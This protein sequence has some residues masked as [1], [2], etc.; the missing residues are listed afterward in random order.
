MRKKSQARQALRAKRKARAATRKS[1][2]APKRAKRLFT[3]MD[4]R[5][6]CSPELAEVVEEVRHLI[7]E[8]APN[9]EERVYSEGKGIGYRV[10]GAGTPFMLFMMPNRIALVFWYGAVMPDPHRLLEG[11][12]K[13]KSRWVTLRPGKEIPYESLSQLILASFLPSDSF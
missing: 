1:A 4:V 2:A 9:A 13:Y 11:A 7:R 6:R 3:L 5:R 8:T 10:P 12:P